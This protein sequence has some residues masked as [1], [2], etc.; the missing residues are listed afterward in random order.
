MSGHESRH[1][2]AGIWGCGARATLTALLITALTLCS[3]RAA[4]PQDT[5]PAPQPDPRPR[6]VLV[7]DSTMAPNTGYGNALCA[8]LTPAVD[9]WNL[10]RGGR[11]SKS[12]R[13]EGLWDQMLARIQAEALGGGTFVLIQFGHNDQPGKPGRSTDLATEFP[14]NLSRYIDELR[15]LGAH[16]VLVTPLTRRSFKGGVLDDQL[17]PWSEAAKRVARERNVPLVDLHALS[18]ALVQRM[19][20]AQADE[21]AEAAPGERR[22]DRTHVGQ[23]GACFFSALVSEQLAAQLGELNR[24]RQPLPVCESVPPPRPT[25]RP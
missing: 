8:R 12:F 20:P 18:M 22:F 13:A 15:A 17:M 4:T 2:T 25:S 19:G 3:A 14:A 7:G 1:D 5:P 10:A 16:P 23:R 6:V 21:L 11:S 9:C 24:V